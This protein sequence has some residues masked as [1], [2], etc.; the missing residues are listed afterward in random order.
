MKKELMNLGGRRLYHISVS[1]LR[2]VGKTM[3]ITT[4]S[5]E[6]KLT[7]MVNASKCSSRSEVPSYHSMFRGFQVMGR[8]VSMMPSIK[9]C[10]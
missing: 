5:L 9:G 4:S 3:H 6:Y 2:E 1:H 10:H 7:C 8:G